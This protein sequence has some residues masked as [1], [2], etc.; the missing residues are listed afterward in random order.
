MKF[1]ID[2]KYKQK[3][4]DIGYNQSQKQIN[5]IIEHIFKEQLKIILIKD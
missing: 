5:S 1:Y 3:L 2:N 4:V